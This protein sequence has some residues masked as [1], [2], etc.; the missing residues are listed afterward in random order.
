VASQRRFR[1]RER[2]YRDD[3]RAVA[4][5]EIGQLSDR[6]T[7]IAGAVAYWCE[8]SSSAGRR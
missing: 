5:S 1:E 4:A 7:I 2:A 8:G 6:E 3:M